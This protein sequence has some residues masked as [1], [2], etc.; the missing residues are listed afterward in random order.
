MLSGQDTKSFALHRKAEYLPAGV[1]KC[2][3][4]LEPSY[5]KIK[6][7]LLPCLRDQVLMT[8]IRQK[9]VK[10]NKGCFIASRSR[11]EGCAV[12]TI[13][14]AT[15]GHSG[16]LAGD[17]GRA[18]M[19]LSRSFLHKSCEAGAKHAL[20]GWARRADLGGPCWTLSLSVQSCTVRTGRLS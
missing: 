16:S 19:H 2:L 15:G 10:Q 5:L 4:V 8:Y 20:P 18:E 7:S 13:V 1:Y 3:E 6:L 12:T 11:E 17:G 9:A 14:L